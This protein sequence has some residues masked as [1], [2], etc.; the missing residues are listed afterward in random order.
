MNIKFMNQ[1]KDIQMG[2]ILKTK[3][4][5]K[6]D[7]IWIVS[8]IAKDSGI[9]LLLDSFDAAIKNGA[10]L[11]I[12]I[13]I[14][15]KNISKDVLLK[16]LS[17]GSNLKVHINGEENKVETRVY[18]YESKNADSYIYITGGKFSEG[19]LLE[20]TCV[21]TEIKYSKDEMETFKLVKNQLLLGIEGVFKT[22]DKDDIVLLANK[23]EIVTRI[24]DRKI[25]SISEL[26]GNKEQSIGEQI[27]DEGSSLRII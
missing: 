5:D 17:I 3:L 24:I 14:D 1:P 13:G 25:P 12:A 7:E 18:I 15:R 20:N 2:N 26:Y 9:E 6:F 11:N 19:G 23:G 16:L 22:I 27:Y 8:G 4:Q 21:I 10:N